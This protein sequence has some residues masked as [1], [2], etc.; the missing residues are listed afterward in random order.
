M[1]HALQCRC[2]KLR[3]QVERPER[4][5]HVVCYCKD[6]QAFAHFLGRP[7]DILDVCGGSEIVQTQPR[8]VRFTE[9]AEHL[10]CVRLTPAG[11]VRWYAGC[12][13]TPI[14]NTM[15]TPKMSF[16]GLVHSCLEAA[17]QP[18][19]DA[20][21]PI[22]CWVNTH[23]AKGPR[24]PTAVGVPRAALWFLSTL[25]RARLDGSYQQTPFFDASGAPV[26][27]PRVLGSGDRRALAEAVNDM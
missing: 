18:L 25:I 9:G 12:C 5:N 19:N 13:N 20:F 14:G 11:L 2:G 23:G 8:H 3:G 6:C 15:A 17:A 27:T 24:R 22:R 10:A 16:V 1:P 21:G 4:A 7:N 26:V